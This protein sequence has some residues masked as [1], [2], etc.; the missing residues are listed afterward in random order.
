[1]QGAARM[2]A[3]FG[4]ADAGDMDICAHRPPFIGSMKLAGDNR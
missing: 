3:E 1:L 4:R 2:K